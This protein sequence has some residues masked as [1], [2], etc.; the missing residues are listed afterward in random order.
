[1]VRPATMRAGKGRL[2]LSLTLVGSTRMAI[3]ARLSVDGLSGAALPADCGC[4]GAEQPTSTSA[5]P[6]KPQWRTA[7]PRCESIH[8]SSYR[9]RDRHEVSAGSQL[10]DSTAPPSDAVGC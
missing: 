6:T 7:R 1:S 3:V 10:R 9:P 2:R 8:D 4:A 5:R